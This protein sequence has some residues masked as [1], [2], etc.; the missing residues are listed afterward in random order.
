MFTSQ[1]KNGSVYQ[2]AF[3]VEDLNEAA[4]NWVRAGAGPF[5]GFDDFHFVE[6]L[7]PAGAESP[8]LDILLGFSGDT[9]IELIKPQHDPQQLFA[10]TGPHHVARLVDD[11]DAYVG[12]QPDTGPKVLF[13]GVFPTGTPAAYLDTRPGLGIITELIVHDEIMSSMLNTMHA[14]A[15][16]FTGADPIRSIGG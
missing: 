9:M 5:Y 2:L 11:I 7:E 15:R 8:R 6:V 13:K 12:A 3:V 16:A 1:H 10:N 14:E 4:Q